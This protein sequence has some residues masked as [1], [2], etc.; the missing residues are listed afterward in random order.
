MAF[1]SKRWSGHHFIWIDKNG[2]PW[3]YTKTNMPRFVPW[4]KLVIYSGT[5]RRVRYMH[6]SKN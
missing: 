4:Y 6:E 1:P 5:V 2:T 3:E